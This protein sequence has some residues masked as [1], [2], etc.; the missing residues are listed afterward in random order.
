MYLNKLMSYQWLQFL[1]RF[2]QY[3]LLLFLAIWNQNEIPQL[4]TNE[5]SWILIDHEDHHENDKSKPYRL[6]WG[7]LGTSFF[8]WRVRQARNSV[9]QKGC[10]KL[11][12]SITHDLLKV[13]WRFICQKNSRGVRITWLEAYFS[14][15]NY[16]DARAWQSWGGIFRTPCRSRLDLDYI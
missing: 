11:F 15:P 8:G 2:L 6:N 12:L 7:I 1:T 16:E 9:L 3:W 14:V 13:Q 4:L 5:F 10:Q